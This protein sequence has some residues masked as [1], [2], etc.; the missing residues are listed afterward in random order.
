MVAMSDPII[1]LKGSLFPLSVLYCQDFSVAALRQELSNKLAQ[2]PGFFTQAPVVI[3]VENCDQI[4]DLAAIKQL[5]TELQLVLGRLEA[6]V[7]AWLDRHQAE[8]T[9]LSLWTRSTKHSETA[10]AYNVR[11]EATHEE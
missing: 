10:G 6:R 7:D 5:F 8:V 11:D 1:E 4:P 9:Q 3:S 2:A